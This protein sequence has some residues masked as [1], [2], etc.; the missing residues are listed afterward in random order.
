VYFVV[1]TAWIGLKLGGSAGIDAWLRFLY[2]L[3]PKMSLRLSSCLGVCLAVAGFGGGGVLA[4]TVLAQD[5]PAA[6]QAEASAQK[7]PATTQRVAIPPGPKNGLL[8]LEEQLSR[9]FQF[10]KPS[11]SL[12]VLPAPPMPQ[13][14]APPVLSKQA[15]DRMDSQKDWALNNPDDLAAIPKLEDLLKVPE[16]GLESTKK[17]S[18]A[19]VDRFYQ[20]LERRSGAKAKRDPFAAEDPRRVNPEPGDSQEA[21]LPDDPSLP[22]GVR[23]SE[24]TLRKLLHGQD[25]GYAPG[26]GRGV[27]SDIFGLGES[28]ATPEDDL[29]QKAY[30]KGFQDWLNRPAAGPAY[31]LPNPLAAAD[32][33]RQAM[34]V[35]GG[36]GAFAPLSRPSNFDPS[37]G[38]ANPTLLVGTPQDTTA[39]LL[40]QWNP[41]YSAPKVEPPKTPLPAPNFDVPRRKF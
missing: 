28:R 3:S 23:S 26:S 22:V 6:T 24:K 11:S 41:L 27:L 4:G 13:R 1:A 12:D 30:L 29:A 37:L 16:Y 7:R 35:N 2:S 10:L 32:P 14:A 9:S 38:A 8:R 34:P 17:K 21:D 39:R 20:D 25:S 40:N 15:K 36:F 33:S 18:T 19:S 31:G 5:R